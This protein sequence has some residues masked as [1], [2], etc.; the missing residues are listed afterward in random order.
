MKKQ[1]LVERCLL[2]GGA[3]PLN[4]SCKP[5]NAATA[6][7]E[8]KKNECEQCRIEKDLKNTERVCW[9]AVFIIYIHPSVRINAA[10]VS[11]SV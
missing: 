6:K 2:I 11:A 7:A 1:L 5:T 10:A 3:V 9:S 8:K 4:V